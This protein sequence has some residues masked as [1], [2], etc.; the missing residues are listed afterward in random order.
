MKKDLALKVLDAILIS[1]HQKVKIK[2]LKNFFKDID[3]DELIELA[4][5]RYQDFG[6]FLYQD[7]DYLELVNRPELSQYLFNFFKFEN[8]EKMQEILEVLA[9]VAYAGPI[10]LKEV[11]KIRQ[12]DSKNVLLELLNEGFIKRHKSSYKASEKFLNLFGF[13]KLEDLPDYHRLRKELKRK[14]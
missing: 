1:S 8:N 2:T 9:I 11:N 6:F 5:A 10:S 13:E 14:L 3:F 7:K 4:K 12:K